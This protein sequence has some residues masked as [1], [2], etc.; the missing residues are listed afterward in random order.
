MMNVI[1]NADD[2]GLSQEVNETTY[3]LISKRI[4]AS[5]TIKAN[6]PSVRSAIEGGKRFPACSFGVRLNLTELRPLS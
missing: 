5:A 1:F 2:L 4:V 3:D 6:G